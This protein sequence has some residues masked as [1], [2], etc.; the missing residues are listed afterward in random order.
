MEDLLL[1]AQTLTEALPYIKRT[2]GKTVVIK[3][4]GAAMT[5]PALRE[6]VASRRRADEARRHQP[7][8][9]ARRRAGHHGLH[10]AARDAGASSSTACA[11]PTTPRWR[12]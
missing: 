9:R 4:G 6:S 1:K 10:G 3:Y 8:H 12:S 5:D 7:G 11:S 2:W